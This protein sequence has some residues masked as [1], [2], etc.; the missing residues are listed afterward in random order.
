LFHPKGVLP[1]GEPRT[2]EPPVANALF[3][4]P[5][6]NHPGDCERAQRRRR[7]Q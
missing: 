2:N 5:S 3:L 1:N 7:S 4:A 6:I